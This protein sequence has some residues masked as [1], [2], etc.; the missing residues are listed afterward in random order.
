LVSAGNVEGGVAFYGIFGKEIQT[1]EMI[2]HVFYHN[3]AIVNSRGK[4]SCL[5][6]FI[7]LFKQVDNFRCNLARHL[8]NHIDQRSQFLQIIFFAS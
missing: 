7:P 5:T 3:R 6:F 2:H 8:I 4:E 1:G